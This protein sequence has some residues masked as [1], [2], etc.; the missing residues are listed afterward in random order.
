MDWGDFGPYRSALHGDVMDTFR[1]ILYAAIALAVAYALAMFGV[2]GEA[3]KNILPPPGKGW[4]ALLALG[5]AIVLPFAAPIALLLG[6][7]A[8]GA[9]FVA[10][11]GFSKPGPTDLTVTVKPQ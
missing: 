10:G 3:V 5:V 4:L 2:L 8:G 11:G 6:L 1:L 9:T 7:T